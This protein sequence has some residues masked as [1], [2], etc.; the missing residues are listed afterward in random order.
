MYLTPLQQRLMDEG[1]DAQRKAMKLVVALGEVYDARRLIPIKS[2]HMSGVSYKI[3]GEEGLQFLEEMADG[4][5][6]VVKS[7]VNPCGMDV[8]RWREMCIPDEFAEKQLRIVR[9]YQSFGVEPTFSCTPY[10]V[11][12]RPKFG[13]HVAW[14][15]SSAV[16][17]ANSVLG[18]RTNREGGPSALAAALTGLTPEYGMHLSENRRATV[19][20]AVEARLSDFNANV[21]GLIL[22][23]EIGDG[24]PYFTKMKATEDQ[25]KWLGASMAAA[26]NISMFHVERGTPEWRKASPQGCPRIRVTESD[27]RRRSRKQ[28]FEG[29]ADIIG[30]GSPHLSATEIGKVAAIIRKYKPSVSVWVFTSRKIRDECIDD[31]R[32]IEGLGGKVLVDTCLEVCPLEY[33]SSRVST[34]SGK[35]A[36]YL[37]KLSGQ[38]VSLESLERALKRWSS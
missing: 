18:A 27:I 30:L 37:P 19:V 1:S 8:G 29:R 35:G 34:P 16:I 4:S 11:G 9:A 25:L 22:G 36:V 20:V 15:E 31:V 21:L 23:E 32:T 38:V 7:T 28:T 12:N 5:K 3:I 14:A 26:G 33:V 6:V 13:E 2:A 10:L 24:I 17:F